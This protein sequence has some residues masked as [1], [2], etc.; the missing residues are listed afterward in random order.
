MKQS[1]DILISLTHMI[2][3]LL[4]K[5][6]IFCG[7]FVKAFANRDKL[8]GQVDVWAMG[9]IMYGLVSGCGLRAVTTTI[10]GGPVTAWAV[11]EFFFGVLFWSPKR[12]P[13]G[14]CQVHLLITLSLVVSL[15]VFFL[16]SLLSC[17]ALTGN[18][19]GFTAEMESEQNRRRFASKTRE[20]LH[21]VSGRRRLEMLVH[22]Y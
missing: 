18:F 3:H 20:M 15:L 17:L 4:E 22:W 16:V 13:F 11:L 21:H 2:K 14:C 12:C 19:T 6:Y 5:N 8:L 1:D 9:V 7:Q 10:H